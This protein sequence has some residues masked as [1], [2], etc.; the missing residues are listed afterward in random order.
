M[1]TLASVTT[2]VR[3]VLGIT[4]SGE[5]LTDAEVQDRIAAAL[6]IYSKDRPRVLLQEYVGNGEHE[7]ALP[8]NWVDGF[9]T[10][11]TIELPAGGQVREFEDQNEIEIVRTDQTKRTISAATSGATQV[12]LATASEAAFFRDGEIV[13]VGDDAASETNWVAANG[14]TTTGVVTLVNALAANY[15]ASPFIRKQDHILFREASPTATDYFILEYTARH[16]LDASTDT[17]PAADLQAFIHLCAAL[18]ARSIAD[19]FA[20]S[21][22]SNFGSDSISHLANSESWRTLADDYMELYEQH[23][24]K[25]KGGEHVP[26]GIIR[27]QDARFSWGRR[28]LFRG[29]RAR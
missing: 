24:G 20:K 8:T 13:V 14:N 2:D 18:V 29:G 15:S 27:E 3:E 4:A 1:A 22:D 19:R 11:R 21:V 5:Q 16:Q 28:F 12:T 17:I 7:Y 9:S 25:G 23:V 26:V 10:L 6:D